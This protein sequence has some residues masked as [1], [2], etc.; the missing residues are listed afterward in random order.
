M[1]PEKKCYVCKSPNISLH[2]RVKKFSVY[3]CRECSL[4]WVY[5]PEKYV[6]DVKL[7]YDSDYY[8]GNKDKGEGYKDYLKNERIH[9]KNAYSIIKKPKNLLIWKVREYWI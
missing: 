3:K 1:I 2:K 9:R 8:N 5:E 6:D 7:F 4:L